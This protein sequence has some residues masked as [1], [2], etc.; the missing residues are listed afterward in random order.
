MTLKDVYF[1]VTEFLVVTRKFL[2]GGIWG[3]SR[4][5]FPLWKDGVVYGGG[6]VWTWI[7]VA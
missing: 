2:F 6:S 3:G 1:A 5:N 7:R 4:P